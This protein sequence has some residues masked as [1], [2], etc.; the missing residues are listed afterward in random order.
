M[1]Y[2]NVEPQHLG[3]GVILFKNAITLNW[4]E[5]ISTSSKMIDEEW[6]QMYSPAVHPETGADVFVNKSGFFFDK[7]D[8]N[9][10]PKRAGQIHSRDE[11]DIVELL[12]FLENARYKYLLKYL[13]VFPLAYKCIWWNVKGHILQYQKDVYLGSHSDNSVEYSY[14]IHTPEDQLPLRS[15]IT[16][17][18]YFN[19]SSSDINNIDNSEYYGG[20]H[21]FNY[22]DI[23]YRPEKGDLIMF[24]SNYMAAHEVLPVTKGVRYSYLGWYSQGTPNQNVKEYVADPITDPQLSAKA[25]N[26]YLP[27]LRQDFRNYLIEKGHESN[28]YA[29][30]LT[31]GIG[32]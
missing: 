19:T 3:S 31:D 30:R 25:T 5:V 24:P 1:I 28:S 14:G 22:L 9:K 13:E 4:E 16:S 10:M 11:K 17:L 6:N 18:I 8:L 27:N 20:E 12:D 23:K 21:Y 7:E 26:V 15:V 29:I 2:N 32:H